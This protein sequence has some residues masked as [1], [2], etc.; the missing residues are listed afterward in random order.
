MNPQ[1]TQSTNEGLTSIVT[2]NER[3]IELPEEEGRTLFL[4]AAA[5]ISRR[6]GP[7]VIDNNTTIVVTAATQVT[8]SISGGFTDQYNPQGALDQ[9]LRTRSVHVV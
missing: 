4:A 7:L 9:A 6:G 1:R 3:T 5:L 8:I 2:I